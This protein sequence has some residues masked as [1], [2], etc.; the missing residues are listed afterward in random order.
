ML[1]FVGR[2]EPVEVSVEDVFQPVVLRSACRQNCSSSSGLQAVN[3]D[4]VE[5]AKSVML[6]M[7]M[8]FMALRLLIFRFGSG[9]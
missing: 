3:A 1:S 4:E 2:N 5:R 7:N 9:R 8:R 6:R